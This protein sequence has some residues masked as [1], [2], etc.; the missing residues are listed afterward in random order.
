MQTRLTSEFWVR[1]YLARLRLSDIPAFVVQR[2]AEAA[3][4][5]LIK[6]NPLDGSACLW[7]RTM[8]LDG[9]REW[10]QLATGPEADVDAAIAR[11]RGFDPDIWVIEVEDRDG[12]T[13]LDE[14]GLSE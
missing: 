11:Q 10:A 14:I 5:V 4:A 8:S 7:Q 13:L 3:G 1:A 2:G 12:R 9:G 6:Q